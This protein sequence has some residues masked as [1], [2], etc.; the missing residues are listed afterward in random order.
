MFTVSQAEVVDTGGRLPPFREH[1]ILFVA[2]LLALFFG[3]EE[4]TRLLAQ[5]VQGAET[6]G[7]R[8]VPILNLLYRGNDNRLL[9]E[10]RPDEQLVTYFRDELRLGI[11]EIEVL[12]HDEYV[13]L[14]AALKAKADEDARL[15][16][17]RLP[18]GDVA[19]V[20]G[21][22]TDE[23]LVALAGRLGLPTVSHPDGSRRG[24]NKLLLHEA[25]QRAGMPVFDTC[26]AATPEEV[27]GCLG[28]LKTMGYRL[29][30]VKSQLGASGIGIVRVPV[31][32]G[33]AQLGGIT[34]LLFF[35]GPCLV[36]GWLEVGQNGVTALTSPSV[37]L[38][39]SD[40]AVYQYDVT[41]QILSD[42]SVH[43]GNESP[44]PY[45]AADPGLRR[46]LVEQAAI[47]GRWLQEQGYRGTA[48]VD[49]VVAH[50]GDQT[51]RVFV[52]EI[53]ARVTGATYPA[54][55]ARHFA[56]EGGWIMRNLR[57]NQPVCG[58]ALLDQLGRLGFLFRP[59]SGPG[60]LPINFNTSDDGLVSK[61]QFLFLAGTPAA[62][63]D[64]LRQAEQALD[65]PWQYVRD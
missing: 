47:A 46:E 12:T 11:P 9:L 49:F 58:G 35:E 10:R 4:E 7:G 28:R 59:G 24:N 17:E 27:Y 62:C 50:R 45:L 65:L 40:G 44:P 55:L 48:S 33:P 22:V 30:A 29:A 23:V 37:Q 41:E 60:I 21:Y 6:Y 5:Q 43:Q 63:R 26:L 53:N 31:D 52:C 36:Q 13:A 3:N 42:D 16:L 54:V 14:G 39:V 61:G 38:F 34:E 2:N 32:A 56:P 20:D 64:L 8:L 51:A 57:L 18:V 15:L 25:M 1:N 19:A